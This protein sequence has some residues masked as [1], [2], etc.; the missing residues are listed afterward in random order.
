MAKL[1]SG[2]VKKTPQSGLSSDRYQFLGLDQ[3]EPNLG[4]P[5]I[6][7][8]SVGANPIKVGSFYQLAAI[9]EYPGERYWST[10][11]GIGTTLGIISVYANGELPNNAFSRIHGLNFV[12]TGVTVETPSVDFIG[13][14]G[15]ATIRFTVT[16]ILN[17]GA[18]GQVLYNGPN[19]LAIGSTDL[20]YYNGNIGIGTSHPNSKL[21]VIG[22]VFVSGVV[23]A[24]NFYGNLSGTATTATNVIG[25]IS[26]VTS[27]SVSGISTLGNIKISSG[28][29]T[30]TTGTA[31]YYGNLIGNADYATVAGFAYTTYAD[32]AG[33]STTSGIS[34][35]VIGGIASV[36]SLRV[37]GI[38]T[39][40]IT[41][42]TQLTTQSLIVSGSSTL[43]FI[44][45]TD[46][47]YTGVITATRF[48]GIVDGFIENAEYA[49]NSGVSTDVVGGI[50]SVS[51]LSVSGVSTLGNVYVN[52]TISG[53]SIIY[54]DPTVVGDDTGKVVIKGDLEVKGTTTTIESQTLIV[55]DKNIELATGSSSDSISDEGGITLKGTTDHTIIFKDID[56]AWQ[57]S[58]NLT[59]SL[60]SS[61]DLGISSKK[62]RTLY[63]NNVYSNYTSTSDLNVSGVS[64]LGITSTTQLTAQRLNVSG[65][66]TLGFVTATDAFYTGVITATR[67]YG[68][69]DG[70][71]DSAVYATNAGVSTDVIGGIASV[72][73]LNVSGVST[74]GGIEISAGIVSATSGI[75]TYYGKFIGTADFAVSAGIAYTIYADT[76]GFS[77]SSGIA[78]NAIN[79]NGGSVG[80]IPYQSSAND[81]T[82]LAPSSNDGWILTYDT[83]TNAPVWSDPSTGVNVG[84]ADYATNAGISTNLKGGSA[85]QIPYQTGAD[86]TAFIPNGTLG[87]LLQSNGN[88]A[89]S[90]VTAT[91]LSVSNATY[92]TNA[93]I[94][95]NLKGGG[96][97]SIPYQSQTGVT[98]FLADPDAN[99]RILTWNNTTNSPQWSDP[100]TGV[101]VGFADYATNAGISTNLKGGSASQIPYQ[102]GADTTAFIP[103]G[104][105]G[106]L[107]QSNGNLAP[108][109]VTATDLSVSNATYATNVI[110]G[111]GSLTSLS[112]SGISTL[113]T[114]RISSGIITS[115]T[116]GIVTYYGD[117]SKLTN[118]SA[119]S[120]VGVATIAQKLETPRTFTISGNQFTAI[121]TSFDGT[122]NATIG[123]SLVNQPGVTS[124]VY[125]D[126]NTIPVLGVN[127][128][129]I[130]TSTSSVT[131]TSV[132]GNAGTATTATNVIGGIG[133]LTSLS[134][135]GISTLGTVRI[136]SGIIT[137]SST[138][139]I[140][141]YYGD[142][143]NLTGISGISS[144]W[145]LNYA[146]VLYP[147]VNN[148]SIGATN[149]SSGG[150]AESSLN[151]N[152]YLGHTFGHYY[153]AQDNLG[154]ALLNSYPSATS[155]Y[156]INLVKSR[157]NGSGQIN[158]T[159]NNDVL[160][161]ISFQG[162]C[163]TPP[164]NV[165]PTIGSAIRAEQDGVG[166]MDRVPGRLMFYTTPVGV[167]TTA[168]Q[169]RVRINNSGDVGIGATNPTSKLHVIGDANIV[170][171]LTATSFR[172]DG[173]Q[174]TGITAGYASTAGIST[175]ATNVIGGIGSITQL[176][177][178][179]ISTFTNGPVFIGSGTSTGT[180]NQRLQVTG[181][182]Y[183]SGNLG[184][185]TTSPRANLDVT[186]SILIS[187]G[188]AQTAGF[189]IKSYTN[190]NGAI[191]FENVDNTNP[192]F[193]IDRDTSYLLRVND[194]SFATRV[195]VDSSGN[196]GIG[197]TNPTSRLD[198][199]GSVNV[200]GVSSFTGSII[201]NRVTLTAV[202]STYT[203]D[204][205]AGNEFLT[206]AAINGATTI[207]LDNLA[208]IPTGYVWRGVLTFSYTS[209]TISWFAGNSGYTVKWDGGSA[210]TPTASDVEKVVIEVV[211]GTQTI[212]I[213]PLK[214][215]A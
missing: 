68:I 182:A 97:G 16:D 114:V 109:W 89:P 4:D 5:L 55:A 71:V 138:T 58:E 163:T 19:G 135:S 130:V 20:N 198:V 142:G 180:S 106:Q 169:E 175:N 61:K 45:A 192:R 28:I 25:G 162:I 15:I 75:A 200:V 52:N 136:S 29:I 26:S 74:L 31:T 65:V 108:S 37:S 63:V 48:D 159:L 166:Q 129:G 69:I 178:T 57:F 98:T 194:S 157:G 40:G 90:W 193:S 54:I 172:G 62:W 105:L 76:S 96:V 56:D 50:A 118:I 70:V 125:G 139:G 151:N 199:R 171:V 6:G 146:N 33:F 93:G 87:Q 8:S 207:N 212:E 160:G 81:T 211:G 64:T 110:G 132:S 128:L 80:A 183:V 27:L 208:S 156:S 173:S 73:D 104:T 127:S 202:S 44:T 43:G 60:D 1:T 82:F 113:G 46:A 134:V 158:T 30:A 147:T 10:Q 189:L 154:M 67:F 59:P 92:A 209:G 23:T 32:T 181:G 205:Q 144:Y 78:T 150:K 131:I 188:V 42:T 177:V 36:T 47:F 176:Q 49:I 84:F 111:I 102:T 197:T 22:D 66:S 184:I 170:G 167:G 195:I 185:G 100:S 3:A 203:L 79:L 168:C 2:R 201:Q 11:V 190:N 179:G 107:L 35:S 210:M 149:E 77:T 18:P 7:P 94:A 187:T 164:N 145:A 186:N 9:G 124:G 116:G 155:G 122:Q 119:S 213:A 112:V 161:T 120:I 191:S 14:V 101:N 91:D 39:L 88:L 123:L 34:T 99:G 95:T 13:D 140:V 165:K 38:S 86:T 126:S 141:T 85:S 103:N 83:D 137:S 152:R 53:P 115:S 174:L 117:G 12:G 21:E 153:N 148:V 214:G 204:V 121:S 51:S 133:S 72:T 196:L 143:S 215:R 41:S 206:A 17:Q 24:S